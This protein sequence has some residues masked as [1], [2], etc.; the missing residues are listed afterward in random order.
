MAA[1]YFVSSVKSC[2]CSSELQNITEIKISKSAI[3]KTKLRTQYNPTYLF[4]LPLYH[5]NFFVLLN[6]QHIENNNNKSKNWNNT[7]VLS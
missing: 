4:C 7:L 3:Q 5:S 6:M 1:N 2:V